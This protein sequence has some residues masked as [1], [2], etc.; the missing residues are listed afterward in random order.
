MPAPSQRDALG[1]LSLTL[2][3]EHCTAKRGAEKGAL[4]HLRGSSAKYVDRKDELVE[5]FRAKYDE[6]RN[7][8]Q[9][10]EFGAILRD[11]AQLLTPHLPPP[12]RNA[13]SPSPS[14]ARRRPRCCARPS[15]A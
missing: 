12:R 10:S 4:V 14:T 15:T 3:I 13:A 6:V 11:S 1:K 5:A 2:L 8:A 9:F 7:S